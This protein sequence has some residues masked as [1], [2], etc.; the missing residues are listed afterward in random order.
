MA[1]HASKWEGMGV[2]VDFRQRGSGET[3][4]VEEASGA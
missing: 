2:G 3:F 1:E 4:G